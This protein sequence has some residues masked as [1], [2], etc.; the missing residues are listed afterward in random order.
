M[1]RGHEGCKR[2]GQEEEKPVGRTKVGTRAESITRGN[3]KQ[4]IGGEENRIYCEAARCFRGESSV[5]VC[6]VCQ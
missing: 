5:S 4:K 2:G 3:Y 1:E 6:S